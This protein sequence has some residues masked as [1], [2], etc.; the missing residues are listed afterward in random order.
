[1][2]LILIAFSYEL[3]KVVEKLLIFISTTIGVVWVMSLFLLQRQF[4]GEATVS[5]FFVLGLRYSVSWIVKI[6]KLEEFHQTFLQL[7]QRV[8]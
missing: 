6:A 7:R 3:S 2:K 4:I 8:D 1:M 5:F